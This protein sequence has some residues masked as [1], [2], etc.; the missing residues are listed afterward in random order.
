MFI[1]TWLINVCIY[2]QTFF[3]CTE[4]S[5]IIILF[6]FLYFRICIYAAMLFIDRDSPPYVSCETHNKRNLFARSL[7]GTASDERSDK[8]LRM[9]SRI[10]QHVCVGEYRY[11]YNGKRILKSASGSVCTYPSRV[12]PG[13]CPIRYAAFAATTIGPKRSFFSSSSS[14]PLFFFLRLMCYCCRCRNETYICLLHGRTSQLNR[15]RIGKANRK[16]EKN[17]RHEKRHAIL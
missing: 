11:I 6:A 17:S 2:R 10:H 5:G 7:T 14:A 13:C 1:Q 16:G 4:K 8:N 15:S 9:L 12:D 3:T